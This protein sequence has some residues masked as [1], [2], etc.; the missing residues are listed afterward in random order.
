VKEIEFLARFDLAKEGKEE[1][2]AE[3]NGEGEEPAP[4]TTITTGVTFRP[5]RARGLEF[6]NEQSVGLLSH[7]QR[8]F[9]NLRVID[10]SKSRWYA[11][12]KANE[13]LDA[14]ARARAQFHVDFSAG[15]PA[16]IYNIAIPRNRI[17][18]NYS[19]YQDLCPVA[20]NDQHLL[21]KF[22]EDNRYTVEYK[23]RYYT[24]SSR[25]AFRKF[26]ENPEIYSTGE[27]LPASLPMRVLFE[28]YHSIT[29]E[30]CSLRGYCP[31]T[32]RNSIAGGNIS[33]V[34]GKEICTVAY[35]NKLFRMAGEREL[36]SFMS[37]PDLY[38]SV[39]LPTKMPPKVK[40]A[41]PKDLLALGKAM[42]FMEQ[43]LSQLLTKAMTALGQA[44]VKY[45]S[46]SS[47]NSALLFINRYL[48]AYN[49][50]NT[51]YMAKKHKKKLDVFLRDC[52]S[53]KTLS[54]YYK[55]NKQTSHPKIVDVCSRY[56]TLYHSNSSQIRKELS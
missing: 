10:G 43:S 12:A 33:V 17:I 38:A 3:E 46:L 48:K 1:G 23:Q 54:G 4:K 26:N 22:E 32:L 56:D 35:E 21:Q 13:Y 2:E 25:K 44:R 5:N 6:Y 31:V 30:H 7:F 24:L 19:P 42:A 9:E 16:C 52:G 29:K 40:E 45:P 49:P 15:R 11:S 47:E 50:G 51:P 39:T 41:T 18:K 14:V 8:N 27:P 20:W 37:N 28:D 53:I 34:Q 55:N 36:L